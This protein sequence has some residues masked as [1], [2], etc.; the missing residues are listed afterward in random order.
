MSYENIGR[1]HIYQSTT[2]SNS[3]FLEIPCKKY[4][5]IATSNVHYPQTSS[6]KS[7]KP[8]STTFNSLVR[9]D[10]KYKNSNF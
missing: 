7:V 1:G 9:V 4:H 3:N 6:K 5:H 8:C 2:T 10:H